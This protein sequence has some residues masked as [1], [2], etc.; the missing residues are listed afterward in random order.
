MRRSLLDSMSRFVYKPMSKRYRRFRLSSVHQWNSFNKNVIVAEWTNTRR[1]KIYECDSSKNKKAH[2]KNESNKVLA[3]VEYKRSKRHI[4]RG[5]FA[6]AFAVLPKR[7]HTLTAISCRNVIWL[8]NVSFGMN[9][10]VHCKSRPILNI[11]CTSILPYQQRLI[12]HCATHNS[13][14]PFKMEKGSSDIIEL[15]RQTNLNFGCPAPVRNY[16]N[17]HSKW[18]KRWNEHSWQGCNSINGIRNKWCGFLEI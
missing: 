13:I 7:K 18:A 9:A 17:F 8:W 1:R 10:T 2:I 16:H 3:R 11:V 15:T 4:A 5:T 6:M 14:L 12:M